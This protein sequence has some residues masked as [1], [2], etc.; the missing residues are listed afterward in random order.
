MAK[1]AISY[2]K[3]H[4]RNADLK[5]IEQISIIL[6]NQGTVKNNHSKLKCSIQRHPQ[7]SQKPCY[8]RKQD[9][10]GWRLVTVKDQI[11]S[12]DI[13]LQEIA[14]ILMKRNENVAV[15]VEQTSII[16]ILGK[17]MI[18]LCQITNHITL[19][20]WRIDLRV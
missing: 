2:S 16:Y 4:T 20:I 9:K 19:I 1:K 17:I 5:N 7:V 12:E 14:W 10:S 18:N 13:Y 8:K 11:K 6:C 3:H 15:L